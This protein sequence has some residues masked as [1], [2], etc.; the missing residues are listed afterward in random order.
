MHRTPNHPFDLK[1][2]SHFDFSETDL[3]VK[4]GLCLPHC[5]TYNITQDENES[6]RGRLALM[7][8][9]AQGQLPLSPSFNQHLDHCLQCR[10][11]ESVCPAKVPYGKLMDQFRQAQASEQPERQ[12]L[13][14]L[15]RPLLTSH[16]K[17]ANALL[18]IYQGT[19]L[20]T[21]LRK[22][23]ILQILR[24]QPLDD[25]L[26]DL[27]AHNRF[28]SPKPETSAPS[29]RIALFTGCASEML[30]AQTIHDAIRLLT[31][32]GFDVQIPTSQTCC[33][34]IEWHA[35]LQERASSRAQ[36][37]LTAFS[38]GDFHHIVTLASGCGAT[39]Q[40]YP[41]LDPSQNS[42]AL[43]GKTVD[44]STLLLQH[45]DRLRFK[46]LETTVWLHSPCT[47]S[48][49]MRQAEAPF[50]LLQLIPGM[51]VKRFSEPQLCCGAA[52][53]HL[54]EHPQPAHNLRDRLIDQLRDDPPDC[55]LSSNVGCALHLRAGIRQAGLH[56][57]VLHP[58]SLL[59]QQ[60]MD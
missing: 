35:G 60:L 23:G 53:I 11:C 29:Q 33:G 56:I 57:E 50:A 24:L 3:C 20:R 10:A 31:R 41:R 44:C 45:A 26:P 2:N 46:P 59:A 7:D 47:L 48:N 54:L 21:V 19:G 18:R 5:P 40:E 27:L 12:R 34:A 38:D 14:F 36:Q 42:Q 51:S 52:G 37:N 13:P 9:W 4:C 55:L 39:L 25:L 32:C 30:D 58:V 43:A 22:L 8:G 49:V 16:R 17:L 15:A 1:P 6:P 28:D